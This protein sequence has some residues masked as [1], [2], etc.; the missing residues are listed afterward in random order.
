MDDK[1]YIPNEDKQNY[2]LCRFKWQCQFESIKQDIVKVPK[3]FSIGTSLIYNVP[4]FLYRERI[5]KYAISNKEE[6][7]LSGITL[8]L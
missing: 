3:V 1:M 8:S 5:T 4:S 2:P 6:I 7:V